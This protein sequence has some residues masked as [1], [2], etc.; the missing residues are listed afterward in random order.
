[1][2][3][4]DKIAYLKQELADLE[5]EYNKSKQDKGS[6]ADTITN[7]IDLN[8][9]FNFIT[10][11]SNHVK[12]TNDSPIED[13]SLNYESDLFKFMTGNIPTSENIDDSPNDD[14]YEEFIKFLNETDTNK[15]L[16]K[17]VAKNTIFD[18]LMQTIT[19]ATNF[20]KD[21]YV[22]VKPKV[23]ESI[24]NFKSKF[25]TTYNEFQRK[26]QL[27]SEFEA[28][29]PFA[30]VVDIDGDMIHYKVSVPAVEAELTDEYNVELLFATN[31]ME[32]VH[33]ID[34]T[35]SFIEK[36]AYEREYDNAYQYS[37]ETSVSYSTGQH[38]FTDEYLIS[39][40][41]SLGELIIEKIL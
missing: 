39:D 21:K 20:V 38:V 35:I 30:K 26:I 34:F 37:E 4:E 1:M 17:T 22:E 10:G 32:T 2:N 3:I 19:P 36:D 41:D 18:N 33:H 6:A 16:D 14:D 29:Y 5:K 27:K 40:I 12:D 31:D 15:K 7:S 9:L 13:N 8:D 28:A 25:E 11:D 23:S 24:N